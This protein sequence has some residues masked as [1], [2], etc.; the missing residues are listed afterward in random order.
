[1]GCCPDARLGEEC[2]YPVPKRKD[3]CPDEECPGLLGLPAQQVW[4]LQE[5]QV[6]LPQELLVLEQPQGLP[7]KEPKALPQE[8]PPLELQGLEQ[9]VL[10]LP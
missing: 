2:P 10:L 5:P 4:L 9:P 7:R 8:L 3:C 6:Q 1:M